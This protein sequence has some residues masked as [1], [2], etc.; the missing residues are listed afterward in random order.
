MKVKWPPGK[1]GGLSHVAR[2]VSSRDK[3]ELSKTEVSR[4][5][6][7]E[8]QMV[9]ITG[10]LTLS[11]LGGGNQEENGASHVTDGHDSLSHPTCNSP[12]RSWR[13]ILLPLSLAWNPLVTSGV[14]WK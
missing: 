4:S 5:F 8:C 1:G 6:Q 13:L 7:L 14:Q 12:I 9:S 2:S 11:G 10:A 3:E